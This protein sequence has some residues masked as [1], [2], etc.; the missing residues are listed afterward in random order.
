MISKPIQ[1]FDNAHTDLILMCKDTM[2]YNISTETVINKQLLPGY[3]KQLPC[4]HTFKEWMKFRYSSL[5]N[6]LARKLRGIIFGQGNRLRI[7]IETGAFSLSDC[8]W[9][10]YR[11]STKQFE[12]ISPYF[13]DFWKGTESYKGEAIPSLYVGGALDKY[14]DN[15]GNLIKAGKGI[16]NEVLAMQLC[17]ACSVSCN[18]ITIVPEGI[19]IKNFTNPNLML[20]QADASG[21][22]DSEDFTDLDVV[23]VFGEKGIE[24]LMVDAITANT[25]RHAGNF[26]FLRDANT[27]NYLGM[28]PLYDFDQVLGSSNPNDV[29]VKDVLQ[30]IEQF[31]IYRRRAIHIAETAVTTSLH[32]VFSERAKIILDALQAK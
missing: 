14:W 28:A 31:P 29:L 23:E 21:K 6:S 4:E 20:E 22:F 10:K 11:S 16:E 1:T 8:Y 26:G 30:V 12:Q 17:D 3:M 32:P 2:V 19:C 5:S 24:M 15:K 13:A 7:N 18:R 25:D 9:L 27:G